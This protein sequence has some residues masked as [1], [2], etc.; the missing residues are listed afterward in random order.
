MK[1]CQHCM[2]G[3]MLPCDCEPIYEEPAEITEA[4]KRIKAGF[5]TRNDFEILANWEEAQYVMGVK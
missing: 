3:T 1:K 4:Y 5:G 2:P